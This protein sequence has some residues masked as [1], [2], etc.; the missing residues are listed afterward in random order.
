MGNP[1]MMRERMRRI[2]S[3]EGEGMILRRLTSDPT[4]IQELGL[5]DTQ[6]KEIKDSMAGSEQEL[7]DLNGKL[8][9]AGMRQVEL[10][11]ADTLDEEALMKAVQES[12]DISTAIA[13]LRVKQLIAAHKV[14][15]PEQRTKLRETM[16]QRM[17][18]AQQRMK[19]GARDGFQGANRPRR[20][21]GAA[22]GGAVAPQ[23]A[24]ANP[25]AVPEAK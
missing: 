2:M 14:L 5:S 22:Q 18:Q 7:K 24:P 13:K 23:P 20:Q 21:P 9:Q 8:E 3:S 19:E 16:K 15:T 11:K 12:G 10:M 1:D 17:E 25:P 6:V 4:M